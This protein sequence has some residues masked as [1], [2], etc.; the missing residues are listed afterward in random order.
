MSLNEKFGR[1]GG[2]NIRKVNINDAPD[3]GMLQKLLSDLS[4]STTGSQ[5]DVSWQSENN[6][7]TLSLIHSR[8]TARAGWKLYRGKGLQ[9][10]LLWAHATNDV[11]TIQNL[12]AEA[13]KQVKPTQSQ[14]TLKQVKK[15][16][17]TQTSLPPAV[18][19]IK[20][21]QS[22]TSLPPALPK[23]RPT[24]TQTSLPTA[25]SP[26]P[27][28]QERRAININSNLSGK[29]RELFIGTQED[30][31]AGTRSSPPPATRTQSLNKPVIK[32]IDL[33]PGR[34]IL[35]HL[36]MGELGIFS[37]PTFLFFLEREYYEALENNSP[38]TL[39]IF[40]ATS[41]GSTGNDPLS[42][43]VLQELA[44]RIKHT[45]RK[46]DI[47]AQ[48][49]GNKFAVLLP[50]TTIS[51]AKSFIQRVEKA[52]LKT[53]LA[54]GLSSSSMKFTF[55]LATLGEHCKTL[56]AFLFLAEKAL[57]RAQQHGKNL[58]CDEDILSA[59]SFDE[60][61][62]LSKSIDLTKTRELV[63]QLISAGIFTYPA[64][65]A[66]L[67][68]EY[69]RSARKER[70]LLI[71]I[72]KVRVDEETFDE[73]SNMLPAPA[74]YEVI[75]RIGTMLTKRDIFAHYG[76]SNFVIMRSNTS[77]TQMQNF[78]KRLIQSVMDE[79]WLTPECP[80]TSLRMRTEIC[81]ARAHPTAVNLFCFVPVK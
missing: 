70:D 11:G 59:E 46:T 49:E 26:E 62:Y 1:G 10:S 58:V 75:R 9:P 81:I 4:T 37:Y 14:I 78:A 44:K 63:S 50:D 51:G 28:R 76:H 6:V 3:I 43:P 18:P 68:H 32:F 53:E 33:T 72:L 61:E 41:T 8:Q 22:Q 64:F 42:P 27:I 29:L 79:E 25:R 21:T 30:M 52:L 80:V 55:G 7:Y 17:Q 12:V 5:C 74:F 39:I 48:Y 77:T 65:L 36:F 34:D 45:Q 47:L 67:E 16:T 54:P 2:S 73:A 24:Q 66:F 31:I 71:V 15:P 57:E 13:L 69:Y 56:Q 19:Q 38:I 35:Q 23:M 20:P 60:D 40:Q